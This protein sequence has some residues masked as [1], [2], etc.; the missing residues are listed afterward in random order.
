MSAV[1][2][3]EGAPAGCLVNPSSPEPA[4]PTQRSNDG[5]A[6]ASGTHSGVLLVVQDGGPCVGCVEVAQKLPPSS[7]EL[8][9]RLS[10][11]V[12]IVPTAEHKTPNERHRAV[13]GT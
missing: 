2:Q 4:T 12:L 1:C 13:D 9:S 7:Y 5:Q 6:I 11:Q 3:D 8:A 10:A